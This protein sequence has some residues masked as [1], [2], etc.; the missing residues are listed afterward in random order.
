MTS[1]RN[2]TFI[3]FDDSRSTFYFSDS[4][5]LNSGMSKGTKDDFHSECTASTY[6]TPPSSPDPLS[7]SEPQPFTF[8]VR[9][10]LVSLL[11]YEKKNFNL[12]RMKLMEKPKLNS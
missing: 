1:P 7:H 3:I 4:T 5:D 9:I 11:K 10:R 12:Y 8:K 6:Y 2:S